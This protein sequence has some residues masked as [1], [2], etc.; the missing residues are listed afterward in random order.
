MTDCAAVGTTSC[1]LSATPKF[2]DLMIATCGDTTTAC[3]VPTGWT[4]V[5]STTATRSLRTFYKFALGNESTLSGFTN[6][7][8]MFISVYRGAGLIST[9]TTGGTSTATATSTTISYNTITMT[10][11]DG[12]S[13]VIG[14][15]WSNG[16]TAADVAPSGMTLRSGTGTPAFACS[17]TN[18]G[19]ASWATTTVTTINAT[20]VAWRSNVVEIVAAP[21]S[22]V[23]NSSNYFVSHSYTAPSGEACTSGCTLNI[24][25]PENGGSGSG[26]YLQIALMWGYATTA[27]TISN[28]YCNSDTGHATWTWTVFPH[29]VLD[30]GDTTDATIYYIAGA[31]AGCT[32][33]HVIF[34]TAL[35]NNVAAQYLEL[36]QIATSSPV[37][38]SAG[39]TVTSPPFATAGAFT[40]GT[41]GDVIYQFCSPESLVASGFGV[42]TGIFNGNSATLVGP[43]IAFGIAGE[44]FVQTTAAAITP[45][46]QITGLAN[47]AV[48]VAVAL[49][50]S[51]GAGTALTGLQMISQQEAT[52][53]SA[54]TAN[55]QAGVINAGDTFGVF[56]TSGSISGTGQQLTGVSDTLGNTWDIVTAA[57]GVPNWVFDSNATAG[58]DYISLTGTQ[59]A[60]NQNWL[61]VEFSGANNTSHTASYDSTMGLCH[62][63]GTTSPY[64]SAP[65]SCTPSTS[66]GVVM[67]MIVEGMGPTTAVTSPACATF[68]FPS[69]TGQTDISFM[70]EGGG[71]STCYGVAGTQSYTWTDPNS[72]AWGASAVA[73]KAATAI[74]PFPGSLMML[75]V[76][77]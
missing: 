71:F 58:N 57:A 42:S 75:G 45:Y 29:P 21:A 36:R 17:D 14:C 48:C 37:D 64:S 33:V 41:S 4:S 39:Q 19:V 56:G 12:S 5:L 52:S 7:T 51:P 32:S 23:V 53:G 63:T 67:A 74:S 76:G 24:Q 8:G 30:T 72:S 70:T 69:Y 1:T 40:P 66:T 15:A 13:W 26:N 54:T 6:G 38:A 77:H 65:G 9:G 10:H 28:V 2:N 34:A 27:P 25:V 61:I 22:T 44:L 20:S 73:I 50:T 18:G 60:G 11:T 16:A 49:L 62:N 43:D 55:F 46:M 47:D 31:T 68:A 3:A 35:F 59:T